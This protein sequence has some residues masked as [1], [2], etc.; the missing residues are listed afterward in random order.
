[1]MS[2]AV[3]TLDVAALL[4]PDGSI[5]PFSAGHVE[6]A[7]A[8]WKAFAE[9][10][11]ASCMDLGFVVLRGHGV[12]PAPILE[13]AESF[14]AMPVEAKVNHASA[15]GNGY[16][17]YTGIGG[18]H[19]CSACS[20]VEVKETFYCGDPGES[21]MTLVPELP[22]F[23][24]RLEEFFK[25]MR[26][27]SDLMIMG[28]SLSLGLSP[29]ELKKSGFENPTCK[30]L[31]GHYPAH[32][33][34]IGCGSHTDCGFLTML[35]S[36]GAGLE[37]RT[38]S[39]EWLSLGD[40]SGKIVCNIGDLAERW[41]NGVYKSTAHRVV[42]NTKHHRTSAIFFNNGDDNARVAALPG[43][44][45]DGCLPLYEETTCAEF[46]Q[47][48]LSHM[49]KKYTG[50]TAFEATVIAEPTSSRQFSFEDENLSKKAKHSGE[51]S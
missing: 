2:C 21:A 39:G 17:G 46:V 28:L 35:I 34:A 29:L 11:R 10:L 7:S 43:T 42:N 41:T 1:M 25:E 14:F 33:D 45:A 51:V 19:N 44:V 24:F 38:A 6:D 26:K 12:A 16:R 20:T 15:A 4:T 23:H 27:I 30:L 13:A 31:L 50:E 49:R 48:R 8:P 18:A 9:G 32:R 37:V 5:L 40:T 47:A 22:S 3:P 36:D